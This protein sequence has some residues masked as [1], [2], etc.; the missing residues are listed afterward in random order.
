MLPIHTLLLSSLFSISAFAHGTI[1]NPSKEILKQNEAFLRDRVVQ[2]NGQGSQCSGAWL[3]KSIILTAKHC[4]HLAEGKTVF[5]NRRPITVVDVVD[6]MPGVEANPDKNGFGDLGL[7]IVS[8]KKMDKLDLPEQAIDISLERSAPIANTELLITGFGRDDINNLRS[9]P[10]LQAAIVK[11]K[12]LIEENLYALSST[13]ARTLK[14][15]VTKKANSS[16]TTE[17][18]NFARGTRVTHEY[19]ADPTAEANILPGDSG[20]PV[21]VKNVEGKWVLVGVNSSGALVVAANSIH[22]VKGTFGPEVIDEVI[23]PKRKTGFNPS[24]R[25][26]SESLS[27]I[28]TIY[29]KHAKAP[30]TVVIPEALQLEVTLNGRFESNYAWIHDPR[31]K[32]SF[33]QLLIKARKIRDLE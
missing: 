17:D 31:L 7:I 6:A 11:S 3:E 30:F 23:H 20:S 21:F 9:Y 22:P 2:L 18:D 29:Q 32:T 25:M 1:E 8:G 26:E 28:S 27:M 16:L 24:G 5:V 15:S 13:V 4:L 14:V 12:I 10:H 19:V 33:D